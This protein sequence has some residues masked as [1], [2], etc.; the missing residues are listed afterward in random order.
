MAEEVIELIREEFPDLIAS[1]RETIPQKTALLIDEFA[2][3]SYFFERRQYSLSASLYEDLLSRLD[4]DD[5]GYNAVEGLITASY[6][7]SG[8][9]KQ[10]LNFICKQYTMRPFWSHRFRHDI[11]AHLRALTSKFS[12]DYAKRILEKIREREECRRDD[13]SEV[14]IP[15]HLTDMRKLEQ[16]VHPHRYNYGF[17]T[18]E[19][20]LFADRLINEGR[21][22]FL[23][24]LLFINGDYSQ[25]LERYKDSYIYESAIAGKVLETQDIGELDYLLGLYLT[26]YKPSHSKMAS[27]VRFISK[28][29]M[30][31]TDGSE[32][33]AFVSKYKSYIFYFEDDSADEASHW[34]GEVLLIAD[35]FWKET[36]IRYK[37]L[38]YEMDF[39]AVVQSLNYYDKEFTRLLGRDYVVPQSS[40][41]AF[42]FYNR[43]RLEASCVRR[44]RACVSNELIADVIAFF[45]F[46]EGSI[47]SSNR[48]AL[49]NSANYMKRCGDV[50]EFLDS[51][52]LNERH[53]KT[54]ENVLALLGGVSFHRASSN[55][56]EHIYESSDEVYDEA[57]F[58]SALSDKHNSDFDSFL[59]KMKR[60]AF[61]HPDREYAD[62]ALAEIGWYYLVVKEDYGRAERQFEKVIDNYRGTN[63]YDNALNW[64]VISSKNQGKYVKALGYE[65]KL[66][67][68]VA[69]DRIKRSIRGRQDKINWIASN[70]NSDSSLLLVGTTWRYYDF[71]SVQ[72]RPRGFWGT[73]SSSAVVA[74]YSLNHFHPLGK[75]SMIKSINGKTVTNS[76]QF[77]A[78]LI[79]VVRGNAVSV[80]IVFTAPD[81]RWEQYRANIPVSY[82]GITTT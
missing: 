54:C 59:S 15:I 6:F 45:R 28:N 69:S 76:D 74:R 8:R 10:G 16:G 75:G 9:H 18:E 53:R 46:L 3:A 55:Y 51:G 24:Y 32:F 60:Y 5:Q 20:K 35:S 78:E 27:L 23:D 72:G 58:L 64:L 47:S 73:N 37:K 56:L 43:E 19:D 14:W 63:A 25:V 21:H 50:R 49:F 80:Q 70:V 31:D 62:D 48:Q 67:M 22:R 33:N 12:H 13:F 79:N 66:Y 1:A 11:H 77:Y 39:S 68:T 81:S 41:S 82:F 38:L 57:L 17:S 30:P 61:E 52:V 42:S 7:G 4:F 2:L 34:N 40:R 65:R 44:R 26:R 36:H 29:I 71:S